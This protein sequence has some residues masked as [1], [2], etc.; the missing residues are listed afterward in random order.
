MMD[1][2]KKR[3]SVIDISLFRYMG[4]FGDGYSSRQCGSYNPNSVCPKL[5]RAYKDGERMR[6][7]ELT[8]SKVGDSIGEH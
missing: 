8:Q 6:K 7:K 5:L 2:M 3:A 4:A 1:Y